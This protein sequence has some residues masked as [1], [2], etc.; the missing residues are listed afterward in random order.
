MKARPSIEKRRKEEQRKERKLQKAQRRKEKRPPTAA[1]Q[2]D[3]DEVEP[4]S[5]APALT[6]TGGIDFAAVVRRAGF[7]TLG[8]STGSSGT[9]KGS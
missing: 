9:N 6:S 1:G 2:L 5:D 3:Q 4:A 8:G 7:P